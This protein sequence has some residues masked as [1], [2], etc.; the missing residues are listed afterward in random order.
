MNTKASL[1]FL[2]LC[3]AGLLSL[4]GC[5][6]D[7]STSAASAGTS[8]D[9]QSQTAVLDSIV[10]PNTGTVDL[11][12]KGPGHR[13]FKGQGHGMKAAEICGL[14]QLTTEQH[15]CADSLRRTIDFG[16]IATGCGVTAPTVE[17]KA[18]IDSLRAVPHTPGVRPAHPAEA[19]GLT[20][21][22]EEQKT[23]IHTAIKSQ[24]QSQLESSCGF[25]PLTV[26]QQSCLDSLRAEM[27]KGP[28]GKQQGKGKGK[29][30]GPHGPGDHQG[31][32]LQVQDS[33]TTPVESN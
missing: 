22:T 24:V 2:G 20:P 30:K 21:P 18:C 33:L 5:L 11:G 17:Q 4:T 25:S 23:C 31:P 12:V 14:P 15:Q 7:S 3:T 19:C 27:P 9:L 28:K 26:E 32:G 16:A 13:E 6:S 29:G 8:S 10:D 1:L